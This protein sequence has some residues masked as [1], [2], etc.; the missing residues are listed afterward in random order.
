MK[1]RPKVGG[2]LELQVCSNKVE[3]DA[4]RSEAELSRITYTTLAPFILPSGS[5]KLVNH[6]ECKPIHE[7]YWRNAV[8]SA[9]DAM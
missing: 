2:A 7:L 6:G 8:N 5:V 1:R 4:R 3:K 9:F